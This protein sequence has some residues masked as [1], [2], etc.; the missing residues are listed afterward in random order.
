M[1]S[2]TNKISMEKSSLTLWKIQV[3][4]VLIQFELHKSLKG[5]IFD[6]DKEKWEELDIR[7]I[8]EIHLCLA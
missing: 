7:A 5:N 1:L 8:S 2:L 3:Q 6:M 4:D